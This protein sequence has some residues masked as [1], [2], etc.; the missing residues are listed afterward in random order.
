MRELSLFT[1]GGGGVYGTKLLGWNTVGYVEWDE[2]CQQIIA[3]RIKDEIFDYAP[4]FTDIRLFATEWASK[5][6]GLVDVIT[7]GF[8]CQ[9]FSAAGKRKADAD[10][11]NMWPSTLQV[12]KAVQPRWCLLENVPGL[13]GKHRYFETILEDLSEAG[14][15]ARWTCL[16]AA[17]VG[18]PHKRERLWI[19]A[20]STGSRL[21]RRCQSSSGCEVFGEGVQSIITRESSNSRRWW[22]TEP[23]VGRVADG[24][25]ARSNRLKALG[26][27]QV[28]AVVRAAWEELINEH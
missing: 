19:L 7:A 27:G 9:P 18:A 16:S 12:I 8:P 2:Y 11:R 6:R 15:D 24:V 3:A 1:G 22:K 10:E 26:N 20:D 13:L 5:Y 28:P 4:I 17:E 21:Q 25:A 14:Y 23:N